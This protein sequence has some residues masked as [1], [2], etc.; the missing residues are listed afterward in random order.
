MPDKYKGDEPDAFVDISASWAL[1]SDP[2]QRAEFDRSKSIK[3]FRPICEAVSLN[4]L[5]H[6]QAG[7]Y[8]KACR[9][10]DTFEVSYAILF[11]TGLS[12]KLK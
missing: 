10:G 5:T 6:N 2:V 7:V 4:E 9:C 3:K 11:V 8:T 1:L 12:P